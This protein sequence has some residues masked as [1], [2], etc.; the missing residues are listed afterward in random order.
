MISLKQVNKIM[1]KIFSVMEK[2]NEFSNQ[3]AKSGI[4]PDYGRGLRKSTRRRTRKA[5]RRRTRKATRRRIV[6]REND[7]RNSFF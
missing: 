5:T 2:L 4:S 7:K 1:L 6:Q 3:M